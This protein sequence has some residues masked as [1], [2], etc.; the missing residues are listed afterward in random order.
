MSPGTGLRPDAETTAFRR[1]LAEGP[2][3]HKRLGRTNNS[4]R[5]KRI[6]VGVGES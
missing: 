6:G 3:L 4:L 5:D 2:S 1:F